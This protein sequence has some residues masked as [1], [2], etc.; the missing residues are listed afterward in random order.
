MSEDFID[1]RVLAQTIRRWW[2]LLL[3]GPVI[4][5]IAALGVHL[6]FPET[7]EIITTPNIY[8]ASTIVRMDDTGL[9]EPIPT[10]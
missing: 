3:L 8:E 1:I 7:P 2:L 10:D 4:G 9:L 6:G 5:G